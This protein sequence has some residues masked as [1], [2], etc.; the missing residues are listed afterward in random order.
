MQKHLI[1]VSLMILFVTGCTQ[2]LPEHTDLSWRGGTIAFLSRRP[3]QGKSG[4]VNGAYSPLLMTDDGRDVRLVDN[5]IRAKKYPLAWSPDGKEVAMAT[6]D[7]H[8]KAFCLVIVTPAE[9]EC[10]IARGV[11]PSWS[12]NG[13]WLA[14]STESDTTEPAKLGVYDLATG[15]V[16]ELAEAYGPRGTAI[17]SS[18]SPDSSQLAYSDSSESSTAIWL[19]D[20]ESGEK[21][22]LAAGDQPAWS[23]DGKLI[24]FERGDDIWTY[25]VSTGEERVLVDDPVSALWPAWSPDGR[26]LLFQS[27]RDG[28]GEIY[29]LNLDTGELKNLT[30]SPEWDGAPSWRP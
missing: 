4:V 13:K 7:E 15:A 28:N 30:N 6:Y 14:F 17:F 18:W 25:D 29:R 12:P 23:P 1:A 20:I 5:I 19:F 22:R 21:K 26:V 10:H 27:F 11:A 24:A 9:S 8:Q 2:P 16:K 3:V